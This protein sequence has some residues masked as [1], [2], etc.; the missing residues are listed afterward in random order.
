K[1]SSSQLN[2]LKF[3]AVVLFAGIISA[4][5][6]FI[7]DYKRTQKA[8]VDRN[9]YE[10]AVRLK[11]QLETELHGITF[12]THGIEAYVVARNGKVIPKEINSILEQ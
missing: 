10:L 12:L 2:W 1:Q 6:Y 7:Q 11:S 9:A 5:E 4:T 3:A 8:E